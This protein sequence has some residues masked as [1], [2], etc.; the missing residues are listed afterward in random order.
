MTTHK[1][2][3]KV[4]RISGYWNAA[5]DFVGSVDTEDERGEVRTIT[6]EHSRRDYEWGQFWP[7]ESEDFDDCPESPEIVELDEE[8]EDEA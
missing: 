5:G 6:G 7:D 4:T 8:E 3:E 1:H 2:I